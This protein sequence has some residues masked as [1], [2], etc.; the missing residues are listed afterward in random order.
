MRDSIP[1]KVAGIAA[2]VFVVA[3]VVSA[4]AL[5]PSG[6]PKPNASPVKWASFVADHRSRLQVS[7]YVAGI[8]FVALLF[9]TSALSNFFARIEGAL[10]GPST[11][12]IAGGVT[13]VAI[14]AMGGTLSAVLDYRTGPG[15]D[16]N[17]VR[18]LVDANTLAFTLVEFPVA[19]L[20]AGAGISIFRNGGLPR[21]L[22]GLA[23]L[24]ALVNLAGASAQ[25]TH[26]AFGNRGL[27]GGFGF[28]GFLAL[29]AWLLVAG[30]LLLARGF[31]RQGAPAPA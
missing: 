9:F 11:L 30:V 2:I 7:N 19:V 15:S 29:L 8:G 31:G 16:L 27:F 17:I 22:G 12:I 18:T 13:T 4:F 24:A 10:R 6:M 20:L 25:A 14:A 28:A 1:Q 26:G 3:L 5:T 23:L 21:W